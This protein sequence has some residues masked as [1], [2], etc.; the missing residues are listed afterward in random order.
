MGGRSG[1]G[2]K[3]KFGPR[4]AKG[5][6]AAG[7]ALNRDLACAEMP[8]GAGPL[9]RHRRQRPPGVPPADLRN[10]AIVAHADHGKTTPVRPSAALALRYTITSSSAFGCEVS[11]S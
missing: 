1:D 4:P 8:L 6:F 11:A 3:A 9:L 5:P 7:R 10:I 2:T